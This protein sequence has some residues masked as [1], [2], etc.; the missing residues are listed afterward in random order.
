MTATILQSELS[1]LIQDSKKKSPDVR[2]A[3]EKSLGELKNIS[4]TSEAQLAG[5]LLRRPHFVDPFVLACQSRNAKLASSAVICLQRLAASRALPRERLQDV[6]DAFQV[7]TSNSLDVQLK[8]LQTLPSLLQIY[9]QD[10]EG[11]LL[12]A[13]LGICGDLQDNKAA[14]VSSTATA[15][16]QQLITTVYDKVTQEDA[17]PEI[18]VVESLNNGN[19]TVEIGPA[20]YDAFRIF[21]DLCA[22]A[23][24]AQLEFLRIKSVSLAF[25]M[26]LID[27]IL[28]NSEDVFLHHPEQVEACRVYLMPAMMKTLSAKQNFALNV[29][30]LR[31]LSVLLIRYMIQMPDESEAAFSLIIRGLDP[32]SGPSWKRVLYI[33]F[34]HRICSD[35]RLLRQTFSLFDRQE[36]KTSVIGSIMAAFVRIA[37]EKPSLI[38]I[39]HQSTVPFRR[40]GNEDSSEGVA[41]LEAAGVTGVISATASADSNVTGISTEWSTVKTPYLDQLDKVDIL[42]PPNTYVYGLVLNSVAAF[43]EG[44][45]KY[46]M[47]LSVQSRNQ[48]QRQQRG[49]KDNGDEMGDGLEGAEL[50]RSDSIAITRSTSGKYNMLINPLK[51]ANHSQVEEV[52]ICA[53]MIDE[54]WPAFLATCSTFLNAALDADFYHVIVRAFQKLTQVAGVL[55]LTTPRDAMLTTL[56]KAAIPVGSMVPSAPAFG[57]AQ[58]RATSIAEGLP[59]T[60]SE[61]SSEADQHPT[62]GT[63]RRSLEQDR[64]SITTRNLLCLRALINLGIALGGTLNPDSWFTV[65][66]TL[67]HAERVIEISNRVLAQQSTK[68]AND[69]T[70]SIVS[71]TSLGSE[72]SAVQTASRRMFEGTASYSNRSFG[73]IILALVRFS[74]ASIAATNKDSW[75]LSPVLNTPTTP[76]RGGRMHQYSRSFSTSYAKSGPEQ[77]ELQFFLSHMSDVARLNLLRLVSEPPT[78][79][80]WRFIF[81]SLFYVASLADVPTSLRLQSTALMNRIVVESMNAL[82]E[83]DN[84]ETTEVQSRCLDVFR[85]QYEMLYQDS[86][87]KAENATLDVEIHV[88]ILDA[89]HSLLEACNSITQSGWKT[90]L[91]LVCSPYNFEHQAK[92]VQSLPNVD[93]ATVQARSSKLVQPS[94]GCLQLI[95]SDFMGALSISDLATF[96]DALWVFARQHDNL[97]IA[98]TSTNFFWN[99]AIYLQAQIGEREMSWKETEITEESLLNGICETSREP[100]LIAVW[101]L[102]V[103]RLVRMT[104]DSRED[105]RDSSL[106]IAVRVLDLFGHRISAALWTACLELG[107]QALSNHL[108]QATVEAESGRGKSLIMMME[109]I[110]D[111]LVRYSETITTGEKFPKLSRHIF[112][113]FNAMLSLESLPLASVVYRGASSL[114]IVLDTCNDLRDYSASAALEL[115]Q[116]RHPADITKV[117]ASVVSADSKPVRSAETTNQETLTQHA[118]VFLKLHKL[119]PKQTMLL[120]DTSATMASMHKTIFDCT[121]PQYTSDVNKPSSEQQS[122]LAMLAILYEKMSTKQD[123]FVRFLLGFVCA[124]LL[125]AKPEIE[126]G[127]ACPTKPKGQQAPSFVAFSSRCVDMLEVVLS[128]ST[129]SDSSVVETLYALSKVIKSKYTSTPQGTDPVLWRNATTKAI[130]V[131]EVVMPASSTATSTASSGDLHPFLTA[132]VNVATSILGPGGLKY[133]AKLPDHAKILADEAFDMESFTRLHKVINGNMAFWYGTSQKFKEVCKSYSILLL[134]TSLI[135]APFYGDLPADLLKAPLHKLSNIRPGTVCP[136]IFPTRIKI[137]CLALD[138]LFDLV[139]QP[140]GTSTQRHSLAYA[141]APYLLLRCAWALKTFIA[142]QPLRSLS[143]LPNLLRLDLYTIITT[144]LQTKTF[145]DAFTRGNL[146]GDDSG[147]DGA[148]LGTGGGRHLRLLYPLVLKFLAVW[149]RVPR[150]RGGGDWMED[151]EARG[152]E[153]GL[154]E[155][156]SVVGRDW[157]LGDENEFWEQR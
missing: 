85:S 93:H 5:D 56:A 101:I 38:G 23:N 77:D 37:S 114:L 105:V 63:P 6:V 104:D 135:C 126:N 4:V 44:L 155:W 84:T 103:M 62:F 9:A 83:E 61:P 7:V 68:D 47:P 144:C 48:T 74:G 133:L 115:W 51:L 111:L 108:V 34:L 36:S 157:K 131:I 120:L 107:L 57:K 124:A 24:G 69:A 2:N 138:T 54:C 89:L 102:L 149:R 19:T 99:V 109:A 25:V 70:N 150:L 75:A 88:R 66:E 112:E 14:V 90:I 79:S 95:G 20:G 134:Q 55:E 39:G 71:R 8:I 100:N 121:H 58:S 3:A 64:P 52:K 118:E 156:L 32:N 141:A 42:E 98:L 72:I 94:F 50:A 31:I 67:H 35:A 30:A 106:R 125:D 10:V 76:K 86:T 117:A 127:Q 15:T 18:P 22:F 130:S 97:N 123:D 87:D 153:R 73:N 41:S 82:S 26:E 1:S 43:S 91:Q 140:D 122:V 16:F 65:L 81:Q 12:A 60:A 29:R 21:N 33:E 46:I 143:P 45:A 137:P 132:V 148:S 28:H 78:Q 116:A 96:I 152:I 49:E 59:D 128:K 80:G 145:D 146:L 53:A 129:A 113:I 92:E 139:V 27:G 154:D 40:G 17:L 147:N 13:I 11:N 110:I 142:D 151:D 136:P 119:F